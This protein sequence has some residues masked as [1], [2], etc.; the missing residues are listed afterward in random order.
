[1]FSSVW[2]WGSGGFSVCT[3]FEWE[4]FHVRPDLRW[5]SPAYAQENKPFVEPSHLYEMGDNYR[6]PQ[7]YVTETKEEAW[8]AIYFK[9][10]RL[11][12][13]HYKEPSLVREAI[14]QN[15]RNQRNSWY[16]IKTLPS[17]WGKISDREK[18]ELIGEIFE[19][20]V[21]MEIHF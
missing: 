7:G 14:H 17:V 8:N 20:Q 15:Q 13:S 10:F 1:M 21:N 16:M 11:S 18:L 2:L 12:F 3:G 6:P 9:P 19:P 5:D 4:P